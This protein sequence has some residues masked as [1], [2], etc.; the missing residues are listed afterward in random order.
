LATADA[1]FTALAH[2][3]VE[4]T[5]LERELSMSARLVKISDELA[6]LAEACDEPARLDEPYRRAGRVVHGRLTAAAKAILDRR[7]EHELDLGLKPYLRPGEL[8]ADLDVIDASLRG[9]GSTLI[10]DDRLSRLREAVRT[11]GFHLCGLDMRQNSEVHEEVV[12][13][14]LAWAGV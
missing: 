14:L 3:F 5:E 7:P 10:A 9:N 11:F 13:E 6:A 2:Y 4:L 8:L 12:A 1:A